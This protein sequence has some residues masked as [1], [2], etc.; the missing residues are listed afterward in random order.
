MKILVCYSLLSLGRTIDIIHSQWLRS[1]RQLSR[2][3]C[4]LASVFLIRSVNL[5]LLSPGQKFHTLKIP[6]SEANAVAREN[7]LQHHIQCGLM[8]CLCV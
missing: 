8:C 6:F 1:S 3:A 2:N 5:E 4:L 7:P